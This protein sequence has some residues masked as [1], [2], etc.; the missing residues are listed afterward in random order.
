[1]GCRARPGRAGGSCGVLVGAQVGGVGGEGLDVVVGEVGGLDSAG[2]VGVRG[3]P[4]GSR[5]SRGA[6]MIFWKASNAAM[7][8]VMDGPMN[9]SAEARQGPSSTCLP[10]VKMS[11]QS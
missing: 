4:A 1:M 7:A 10:S 8:S 11:L 3:R 5:V 2:G 6:F 9:M